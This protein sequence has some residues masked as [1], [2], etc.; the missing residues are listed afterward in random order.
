[1]VVVFDED[2]PES[3]I[4]TIRP[5]IL[6]KGADYRRDEVV[7]REIVESLGGQVKLVPVLE[8]FSTT[9]IANKILENYKSSFSSPKCF[10]NA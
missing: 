1:L 5:N 10:R 2:T 4:K 7:G 8:G 3:L 6:V 9:D